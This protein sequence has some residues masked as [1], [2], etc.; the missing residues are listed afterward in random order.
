MNAPIKLSEFET[1]LIASLPDGELASRLGRAG[2]PHRRVEAWKWTDLRAALAKT[3]PGAGAL[4]IKTSREPDRIETAAMPDLVMARLAAALGG[5]AKVY[6]LTEAAPLELDVAIEA[7]TGHGVVVIEVEAGV[8]AELRERYRVAA[9]AFANIAILIRLGEGASLT[10][11]VEQA[12]SPDGVLVATSFAELSDAS[13]F[14]QTTLGLGG[15]LVRLETHVTHP[16][17]EAEVTLNGAYVLAEGRHLDQ[18]TQVVHAGPNGTTREL[19]KGAALRGGK[20]VFQ[21]KIH[22]ERAAQKTDAQMNHRGL[23]LDERAEISTK[24]E[25]E[26][27]ADD[28]VCAHGAALGAVDA[29]ALFYMRQRGM[30]EAQARALLTESFLAEPL[31]RVAHDETKARWVDL[32]RAALGRAA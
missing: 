21:G 9:G 14:E 31:D 18:T 13:R 3:G 29:A 28:V 25:L 12:D 15:R 24:P 19:F 23:L 10:R 17:A 4:T 8:R 16:G 11:L 26:I 1:A 7:G 5:P 30:S 6:A 27:Y 32:I 20:G 22:V 2:L